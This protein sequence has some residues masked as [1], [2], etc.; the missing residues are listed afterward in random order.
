MGGK[1]VAAGLMA[2]NA[3]IRRERERLSPRRFAGS[4][5]AVLAVEAQ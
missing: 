1:I 2:L 5:R 4:I 3:T